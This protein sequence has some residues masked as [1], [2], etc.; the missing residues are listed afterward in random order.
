MYIFTFLYPLS[1][2]S[3][4]LDITGTKVV[5]EKDGT[6][7]EDDDVLRCSNSEVLLILEIDQQ[8]TEKP[9]ESDQQWTRKPQM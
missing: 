1:T 3:E 2:A 9:I 7:I 5:I 8:W 4:K 6:E